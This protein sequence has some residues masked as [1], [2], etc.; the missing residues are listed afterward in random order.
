MNNS[1]FLYVAEYERNITLNEILHICG[2]QH[3]TGERLNRY[4]IAKDNSE[5]IDK[6]FLVDKGHEAGMELHC[7]SKNGIIWILNE[8][9]FLSGVPSLIT[10]LFGRPNQVKRLYKDCG[11]FVEKEILDACYEHVANNRNNL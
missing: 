7:V 6:V 4:E 5:A 10:I 11:L 1:N 3:L 9:K 8:R 2:T